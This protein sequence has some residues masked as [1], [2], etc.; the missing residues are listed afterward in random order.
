[1]ADAGPWTKY[2]VSEPAP[3]QAETGPWS[4]YTQAAPS[5]WDAGTEAMNAAMLGFGPAINGLLG[6]N[7]EA[8]RAAQHAYEAAHP[9]AAP[10]AQVVGGAIPAAA[11]TAVG[12]PPVAAGAIQGGANGY[13]DAG[14]PGGL[15][16]AG[17][18]AAGAGALKAL[19]AVGRA[20]HILPQ[21]APTA[22]VVPAGEELAQTGG[23]QFNA[24]RASGATFPAAD[25]RQSG[26]AVGADLR[27]RGL[28]PGA[29]GTAP[30]ANAV[31]A[32]LRALAPAPQTNP[33]QAMTGVAPPA[34]APVPIA[35]LDAVRKAAGNV[36]GPS[37]DPSDQF[38][39][40][41]VGNAILDLYETNP[42]IAQL[43]ANAR[44]NTAAGFRSQDLANLLTRA[45]D[46]AGATGSGMNLGNTIRQ[47]VATFIDP[48]GYNAE[49]YTPDEIAALRAIAR[50]SGVG[51]IVR[52]L[53]NRLGGGGG[54]VATTTGLVA[55]GTSGNPAAA[56]IPFIGS[57]L[58]ALDN[59]S[60]ANALRKVDEMTRMR[61]PLYQQ[62][63]A[64]FT[65]PTGGG[66]PIM[67]ALA[68]SGGSAL[69][70]LLLG[71]G[72]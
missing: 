26:N 66:Q 13:A 11:M 22:P 23:N 3:Q 1:M 55:A 56:A 30:K 41:H 64:A 59:R 4:K 10:V 70:N 29:S 40:G 16:G 49:G 36:R 5:Q 15:M 33:M 61:S 39:A 71:G 57:A 46:R 47:R 21:A 7:A 72:Q 19:G 63:A 35:A 53:G 18:G 27:A 44:G 24:L 14:I 69:A 20:L 50:P 51:A 65:P 28:T 43:S 45:E 8:D 12:I 60:A 34:P 25:V 37:V 67:N 9:V 38:G 52:D 48:N 54:P 32:D 42:A 6:G 17:V 31:A 2:A 58:K 68:P 62:R